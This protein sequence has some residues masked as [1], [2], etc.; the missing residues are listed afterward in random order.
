MDMKWQQFTASVFLLVALFT[1]SAQG[2]ESEYFPTGEGMRF[3]YAIIMGDNTESISGEMV[4]TIL[5]RTTLGE[6][7]AIPLSGELFI[8]GETDSSLVYMESLPEG[9][10]VIASKDPDD[11][12]PKLERKDN[13]ELKFPL[14]V[15][16][17]WVS[18]EDSIFFRRDV[19][20][21]FTNVIE[22]MDDVVTVPAGTFQKCMKVREHFS[23]KVN[24]GSY[25][26]EAE[27]T[28]EGTKWYAPGVGLIK[29]SM[30]E[31]SPDRRLGAGG[32]IT[33]ELKSIGR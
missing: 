30:R 24:L 27:V 4:I 22:K 21:P 25:D 2:Q 15:G 17:T 3:S 29:S 9:I 26:G 20:Y 7:Q 14:A 12:A 1:A 28:V 10:K 5:P 16:N 18:H 6:H 8:E 33:N 32:Q 31:Q 23:G 19:S 11:P 13:W